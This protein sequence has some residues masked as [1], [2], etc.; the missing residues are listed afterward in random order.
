MI[1]FSPIKLRNWN[2]NKR[3]SKLIPTQLLIEIIK[4]TI[5]SYRGNPGGL[6]G[7]YILLSAKFK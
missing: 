5:I 3:Y 1:K 2:N 6:E 7:I 4:D